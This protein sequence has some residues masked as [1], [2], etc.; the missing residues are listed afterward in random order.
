MNSSNQVRPKQNNSSEETVEI[1]EVQKSDKYKIIYTIMHVI[2][3]LFA[4][5]LSWKCND[6]FEPLS[7]LCAL[8]CPYLYIIWALATRG[9]C[10]IFESNCLAYVNE[11]DIFEN[12]PNQYG[13]IPMSMQELPKSVQGLQGLQASMQGMPQMPQGQQ[14]KM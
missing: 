2:I 14:F 4:I 13:S 9:G 11:V 8:I 6:G 3:S 12:A 1:I 5:Y 7:F 10:G